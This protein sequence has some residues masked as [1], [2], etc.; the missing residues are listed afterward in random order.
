ML[1]G[2]SLRWILALG[3]ISVIGCATGERSAKG[4]AEP[5]DGNP[6]GIYID[7][8]PPADLSTPA[9]VTA[10]LAFSDT[11]SVMTATALPLAALI[12]AHASDPNCPMLIDE[13]DAAAGIID[14][15][16][17]G[18]C[19]SMD[20]EVGIIRYDGQLVAAGDADRTVVLFEDFRVAYTVDCNG[21]PVE[22]VHR[23]QGALELPFAF[24][25][26]AA[27]PGEPMTPEPPSGGNYVVSI[28]VELADVGP[29]C[30]Q[31]VVGYAYDLRVDVENQPG[32]DGTPSY[33]IIQME[34]R[35]A[36]R[37]STGTAGVPMGSWEIS[38]VD[39][40]WAPEVCASEPLQGTLT[41]RAGGEEVTVRP[42]GATSCDAA[43]QPAC[44]PWSRNGQD[45]PEPICD[46]AGC[47]AGPNAPPPWIALA[48]LLA[49]L[50]WQRRRKGGRCRARD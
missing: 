44:A 12:D 27:E 28:L 3:M 46:Y 21:I 2:N 8:T 6:V 5:S 4:D 13:S 41:V 38:A 29:A 9:A 10:V 20:E 47:S 18:G 26:A 17:Q 16:L 35:A 25:F 23:I 50:L 15:R 24:S 43:D 42:D 11:N 31:T 39:Y 22:L 34:G 30:E 1:I 19:T 49:G 48:I 36:W 7:E 32:D 14:W 37:D 45:Q 33:D 40:A